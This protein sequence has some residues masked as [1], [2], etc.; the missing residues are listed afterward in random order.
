MTPASDLPSP[1][2]ML[3]S[4]VIFIF[5]WGRSG[6]VFLQSLLD[7]HPEILT[8]PASLLMNFHTAWHR[9]DPGYRV[10]LAEGDWEQALRLLG[11][12]ICQ[13]HADLFETRDNPG[14]YNL[15]RMGKERDQILRVDPALFL[16]AFLT[17]GGLIL[18]HNGLLLNRKICFLLLHYAY[19]MAQGRELRHK[20][21][22]LYQLHT[23]DHVAQIDAAVADF[24]HARCLG[25][26]RD[27]VRALFSHLR[28]WVGIRQQ[29]RHTPPAP[30]YDFP[31]LV[32]DGNYSHFYRQ[33]LNGWRT[34]LKKY[35]WPLYEI[36][37]ED[38]HAHPERETRALADW[39]KIQ[40]Y[41]VLLES[42]FNGLLYWGDDQA[43]QEQQGFSR[44][45]PLANA[46]EQWIS[47]WD[48]DVLYGLL[49]QDVR[50][51]GYAKPGLLQRR[52]LPLM[53]F[54]PTR[55]EQMALQQAYR[56]DHFKSFQN[57]VLAI[58]ER[59]YYSF[60]FLFEREIPTAVITYP[61]R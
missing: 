10:P 36:K 16:K 2:Q 35:Q 43:H 25:M 61:E 37:L 24:P 42:T 50:R 55:L 6:S 56:A 59:W 17:L 5:A 13:Y 11:T 46:W 47:P 7:G 31:E 48:Q 21:I 33:Q 53:I 3:N 51:W 44:Q 28:M 1:A 19:E 29:G 4:Q 40:W 20:K 9:Y 18:Q 27:P 15:H 58:L 23:P 8:T 41:P 38:L 12:H 14:G 57:V 30:D 52:L 34:V 39:L 26:V 60:Q 32:T 22:I 45:H 49:E 54:M